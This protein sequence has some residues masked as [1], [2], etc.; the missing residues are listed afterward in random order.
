MGLVVAFANDVSVRSSD[1]AK[2][3]VGMFFDDFVDEQVRFVHPVLDLQ[4]CRE[5]VQHIG[6]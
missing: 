1:L 5:I 3:V 4:C 6:L 2:K